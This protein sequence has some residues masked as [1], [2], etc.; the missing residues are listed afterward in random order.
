MTELE[1]LNQKLT[2]ALTILTTLDSDIHL[3]KYK[4]NLSELDKMK[5]SL[6]DKCFNTGNCTYITY[7]IIE[8]LYV[9]PTLAYCKVICIKD[10]SNISEKLIYHYNHNEAISLNE[11]NSQFDT[12]LNKLLTHRNK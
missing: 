1:E 6:I 5:V 12:I 11:F 2:I 9:E 7:R 4:H 10:D 8:V 3:I